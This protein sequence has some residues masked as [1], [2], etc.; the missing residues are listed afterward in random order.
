MICFARLSSSTTSSIWQPE[1]TCAYT[2]TCL[3]LKVATLPSEMIALTWSDLN[4][5]T[6]EVNVLRSC[7]RDRI[8]KT[9]TEAFCRPVPLH[10]LVLNALLEW[11]AIALCNGIGFPISLGSF[12]RHQAPQS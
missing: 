10:P 5:R 4:I 11:R 7:V 9:K 1:R 2:I 3:R 6:M 12:Q 8:G